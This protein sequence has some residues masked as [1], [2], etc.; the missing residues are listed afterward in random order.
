MATCATGTAQ[1]SKEMALRHGH[2]THDGESPTYS[3]WMAMKGRCLNPA[4]KWY[5]NYGG[6]GIT[7]CSRWLESFENF[8]SD[9]GKRP[10][11]MTLE[12]INNDGNYEPSNCRWASRKEQARNMRTNH[13]IEYRGVTKP[14]AVW[15]E[16]LGVN[17]FALL[18]RLRRGWTVEDA[19]SRPINRNARRLKEGTNYGR[20]QN[21]D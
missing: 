9:M 5:R 1:R 12:R 4:N 6:R 13:L 14:L 18:T 8:L 2:T 7:V 21:R 19:F 16:E 10:D 17:G 15:A 3:A 20:N 11:S